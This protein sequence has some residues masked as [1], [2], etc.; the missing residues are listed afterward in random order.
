MTDVIVTMIHIRKAKICSEGA[1]R[2]WKRHNLDWNDHLENGTPAQKLLD[3]GDAQAAL[4]VEI[5]RN[6]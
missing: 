3:T 5:A 1:R 6:G 2:F 4:V